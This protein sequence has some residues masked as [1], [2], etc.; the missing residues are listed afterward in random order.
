[1]NYINDNGQ[2]RLVGE[3]T[4][5]V[6]SPAALY[7]DG[8]FE[9]IRVVEG[10]IPL[11]EYH[12]Q[13]LSDGCAAIL[14]S[15]HTDW[16]AE[17][18]LREIQRTV[19]ANA[20]TTGCRVRLHVYYSTSGE[21]HYS[22]ACGPLPAYPEGFTIGISTK[23][24]KNPGLHSHLKTSNALPYRIAARDAIANGWDDAILLNSQKVVVETTKCNILLSRGGIV[25]VNTP[26]DGCIAGVM[27]AQLIEWMREWGL[28]V[29]EHSFTLDMLY[30]ADEIFLSNAIRGVIPVQRLFPNQQYGERRLPTSLGT[31]LARMVEQ[32]FIASGR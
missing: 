29:E 32:K 17:F 21:L 26:A 25:F 4:H 9:T 13:R 24:V 16:R 23:A 10:R 6:E 8:L 18:F 27:R 31:R 28:P 12:W 19:D 11:W 15:L 5:L 7:G 3:P 1:M 20:Q 14:Y 22:I 2:L 30:E